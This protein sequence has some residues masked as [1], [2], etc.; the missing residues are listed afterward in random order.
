MNFEGDILVGIDVG[1][2]KVATLVGLKKGRDV[3]VIGMGTAPSEGL[4][5]GVVVNIES[6]VNS[7]RESVK[8]AEKSAG[9]E[10]KSAIVGVSGAHIKSFNSHAAAVIKNPQEVNGGDVFNVLE[11]AKAVEL[12]NDREILHV[13]T[14]EFI[15][16]DNDGIKDPRGMTGI[17]LE[18][19]VHVITDDIPSAKNLVRCA[20]RAGIDVNDIVF[21]AIASSES[22]LSPEEKEVGVVLLDFGGGTADMAVY[23]NGSLRHTY[24]LPIGGNYVSSD[25]AFGLKVPQSDAE[26]IKRVDGCALVQKVKKDELVE[27]PGIGGRKPRLIRRQSLAEMIEPRVEEIFR[28]VFRELL[29]SGFE[30]LIGAGVVITGGSS[31]LNS[32]DDLLERVFRLPVRKAN[33]AGVSGLYDLVNH[34]SYATSVGLILYGARFVSKDLRPSDNGR[35]SGVGRKIMRLFKEFL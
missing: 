13:L 4:R 31:L 9:V 1:S 11:K 23:Y 15:V 6:T 19:K 32:V 33:P 18:A 29:R 24:V 3:E 14:Q 7:I 2:T 35:N 22:V 27:I 8:S 25:I 28:L 10:I 5:K 12:P 17:R 26:N 30:D 21:T 20:E 16:D 34:P